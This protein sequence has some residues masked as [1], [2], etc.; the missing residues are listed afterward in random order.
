MD[1]NAIWEADG[2]S[3]RVGTTKS[4]RDDSF[5]EDVGPRSNKWSTTYGAN[6][7]EMLP[8]PK[9]AKD[10]VV[11]NKSTISSTRDTSSG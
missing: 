1:G 9:W 11:T 10:K 7:R 4:N 3:V 6:S 5:E 8:N 2:D